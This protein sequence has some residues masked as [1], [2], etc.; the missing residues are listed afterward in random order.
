MTNDKCINNLKIQEKTFKDIPLQSKHPYSPE[1]QE[2]IKLDYESIT[3][4][5]NFITWYIYI[6]LKM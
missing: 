3:D 2:N 1:I 6:S 4:Q 5:I